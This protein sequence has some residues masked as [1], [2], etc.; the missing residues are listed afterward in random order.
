MTC[1]KLTF[2]SFIRRRTICFIDR[3]FI[4]GYRQRR[5]GSKKLE[6][7]H[8]VTISDNLLQLSDKGDESVLIMLGLP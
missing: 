6:G 7:P 5:R 1:S 8:E 3:S 2:Y 4:N